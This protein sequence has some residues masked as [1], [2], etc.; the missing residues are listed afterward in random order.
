MTELDGRSALTDRLTNTHPALRKCWHPVARSGEV[1]TEPFRV[2]LLGEPWVI[3]RN[4]GGLVAFADR[5]PHRRAPLS[6]GT[7]EGE[8]LRC[9]YHGW[10]FDGEGR[11][12][13]IPALGPGSAIPPAA[14]LESPFGVAERLGMIFLAPE[15]PL[16]GLPEVGEEGVAGFVRLELAP[17]RSRVSAGLMADNFLDFAH[18][19]FV[20]R[21]TFGA[22]EAAEI[23]PFEV[24]RDGPGLVLEYEHPFA[25][26]E[27]PAVAAGTRPLVQ[28]RRMTYRFL[29]PF[30][31]SLKIEYLE[32]GGVN[33]IG[34]FLQ[35]ESDESC[36][37]YTTLWRDDV[38]NG[39]TDIEAALAFEQQVLDEDL[40]VQSRYDELYLPLDVRAEV[41]TRADRHT[42]ELRRILAEFVAEAAFVGRAGAGD[43]PGGGDATSA[44]WRGRR[45]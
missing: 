9:A 42:V 27:D 7:R 33:T 40:A 32:A 10:C 35:P 20:H 15:E 45:G 24:R 14:R 41:H 16:V 43:P 38:G 21:G 13:E 6:L 12:V 30:F 5:C 29:V 28:T 36:R 37:I 1:G 8:A 11:C 18:F 22:D 3:F 31:L 2:E 19:P 25:N 39:V 34:F 26:R 23:H 44:G 4:A 17:T